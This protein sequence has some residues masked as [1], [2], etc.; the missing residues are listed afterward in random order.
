VF[1]ARYALGPYIKHIG[2]V[3]KGLKFAMTDLSFSEPKRERRVQ[4]ASQ[5]NLC[6]IDNRLEAE[7]RAKAFSSRRLLVPEGALLCAKPPGF[8]LVLLM[9]VVKREHCWTDTDSDRPSS[10]REIC[11]TATSSTTNLTQTNLGKNPGVCGERPATNRLQHGRIL[12][13]EVFQLNSTLK[14]S[15]YITVNTLCL[16]YK[17]RPVI[18]VSYETGVLNFKADSTLSYRRALKVG[19]EVFI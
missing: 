2:F 10:H 5:S 19:M 16:Y 14:L 6:L 18:A 4:N 17:A 7:N 11:S 8:P 13:P 1:T 15:L 3:F 12:Q 9:K